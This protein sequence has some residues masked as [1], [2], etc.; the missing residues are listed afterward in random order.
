VQFLEIGKEMFNVVAAVRAH[1]VARDLRNL[2]GI[3]LAKD[4][5]SERFKLLFKLADFVADIDV[6]VFGCVLQFL[7]FCLQLGNRLL[8]VQEVRVHSQS[9]YCSDPNQQSGDLAFRLRVHSVVAAVKN[10]ATL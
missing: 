9:L 7:D 4:I 1:L 3:E 10:D 2:P 5:L 8:E 6:S